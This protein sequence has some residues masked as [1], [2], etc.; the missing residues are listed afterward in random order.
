MEDEESTICN[1]DYDEDN[2]YLTM[3]DTDT[4]S[5]EDELEEFH[6]KL[7]GNANIFCNEHDLDHKAFCQFLNHHVLDIVR[8]I[9]HD[10]KINPEITDN[11]YFESAYQYVYNIYAEVFGDNEEHLSEENIETISIF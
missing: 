1:D 4:S 8:F 6:R 10:V 7:C 2:E 5:E 9:V 11:E 3:T